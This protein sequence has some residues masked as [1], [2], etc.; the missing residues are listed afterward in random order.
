LERVPEETKP[1]IEEAIDRA[2]QGQERATEARENI[3]QSSG[4]SES[5][6]PSQGSPS[7]GSSPGPSQPSTPGPASGRGITGRII[8][9]LRG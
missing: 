2:N 7:S 6:A 4:Q 5:S 9:W 3:P 1:A 8:D